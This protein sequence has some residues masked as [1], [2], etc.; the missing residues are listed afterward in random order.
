MN[1][2]VGTPGI[3][4][5]ALRSCF[6]AVCSDLGFQCVAESSLLSVFPRSEGHRALHTPIGGHVP[7]SGRP[8]QRFSRNLSPAPFPEPGTA[9]AS[10]YAFASLLFLME[11]EGGRSYSI[12]VIVRNCFFSCK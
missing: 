2:L 6:P 9:A 12:S 1:V 8:L 10:L 11:G 3:R 5:G 7:S 4:E